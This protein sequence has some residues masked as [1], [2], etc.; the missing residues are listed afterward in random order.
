MTILDHAL[1]KKILVVATC[2][3]CGCA[4]EPDPAKGRFIVNDQRSVVSPSRLA[5]IS[6]AWK[7]DPVALFGESGAGPRNAM[8]TIDFIAVTEAG[9]ISPCSDLTALD[10]QRLELKPF[11]ILDMAKKQRA[12]YSPAAYN[13]MWTVLACG[14][15]RQWRIHDDPAD[16]NNPHTVLL[17]SAG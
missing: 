11:T 2:F 16:K 3:L 17:W 4:S 8:W 5:E 6:R 12:T 1:M 15:R 7:N 14:K 10:F 9:G 13:E